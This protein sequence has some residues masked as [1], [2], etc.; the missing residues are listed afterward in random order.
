M[1]ALNSNSEQFDENGL[2]FNT[3]TILAVISDIKTEVYNVEIDSIIELQSEIKVYSH[4]TAFML[5]AMSQPYHIVR[6]PNIDKPI[7]FVE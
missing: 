7:K 6:I 1:D 2:D 5:L 4:E 3:E